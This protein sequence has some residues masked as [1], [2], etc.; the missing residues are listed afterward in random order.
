MT[1]DA[2]DLPAP[3]WEIVAMGLA[4]LGFLLRAVGDFNYVGFFK[5]KT[6]TR[7]RDRR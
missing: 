5:K 6:G 1:R 2:A 3:T 4:G 7:L